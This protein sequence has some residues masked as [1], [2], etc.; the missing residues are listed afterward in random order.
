MVEPISAA[1]TATLFFWKVARLEE[2]LSTARQE[3]AEASAEST[4]ARAERDEMGERVGRLDASKLELA[5]E[6][7]M[8]WL[9][10]ITLGLGLD[11]EV[12]CPKTWS[13]AGQ[14]ILTR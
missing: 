14:F 7:W 3:V 10:H 8:V 6:V 13:Q 4:R 12:G 9:Q 5:R 2:A 1:G 11:Y